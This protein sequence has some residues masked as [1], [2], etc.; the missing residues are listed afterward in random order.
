MNCTLIMLVA[1]GMLT[2]CILGAMYY[3]QSRKLKKGTDAF[4]KLCR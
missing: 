4:A 2:A 3:N 1:M